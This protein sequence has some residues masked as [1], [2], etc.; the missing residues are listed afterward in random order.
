MWRLSQ[1]LS[2][3]IGKPKTSAVSNIRTIE[4]SDHRVA[5]TVKVSGGAKC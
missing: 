5:S 1:C 2:K 3:C 4:P